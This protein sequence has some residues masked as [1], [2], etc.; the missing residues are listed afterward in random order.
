MS[1]TYSH[2]FW[3]CVSRAN[4]APTKY[5]LGQNNAPT[6]YVLGQNNAP[7]KY[8]LGQNNVP[9]KYVPGQNNAPTKFSKLALKICWQTRHKWE[10]ICLR[11]YLHQMGS[12]DCSRNNWEP[13]CSVVSVQGW[14]NKI[15]LVSV[16]LLAWCHCFYGDLCLLSWLGNR[17]KW[18]L[19]RNKTFT[20]HFGPQ[21]WQLRHK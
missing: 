18:I 14:T 15:W 7:T 13:F 1:S 2:W 4:N 17:L 5:V 21:G 6:K 8:V 9:T 20:S 16:S 11:M 3:I 12:D 10:D 19:E